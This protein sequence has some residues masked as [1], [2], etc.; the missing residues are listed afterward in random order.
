MID[1]TG[2]ITEGGVYVKH[3]SPKT[4]GAG[5]HKKWICVCP[6]CDKEF[7]AQ[8]NHL[9]GDKI[10]SCSECSRKRFEN[11]AGQRFG[12]LVVI[13]RAYE[14][15]NT[16]MYVCK[17]DCGNHHFATVGHLK[18]G[19]VKS[20]GCLKSSYEQIIQKVLE[21]NNIRFIAEKTFPKLHRAGYSL[22]FDFYIPELN[23]LVEMQGQQHFIPVKFWGAEKG[24]Q[25]RQEYDKAKEDFCKQNGYNLLKIFYYDDVEK[26]VN[27]EIVWPLRK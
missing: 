6:E 2:T 10:R 20:C 5:K 8:S 7:V 11:L 4:G 13:E 19:T 25:K 14:F 17:C 3:V 15:K 16:T 24:L 26:R 22:R 9:I 27:E 18:S 1:L 23:M 21:E 12:N